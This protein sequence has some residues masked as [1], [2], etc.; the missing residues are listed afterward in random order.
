MARQRGTAGD[1]EP[2]TLSQGSLPSLRR[3]SSLL[4]KKEGGGLQEY[5]KEGEHGQRTLYTTEFS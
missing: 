2:G 1:R 5:T 3:S 4:L